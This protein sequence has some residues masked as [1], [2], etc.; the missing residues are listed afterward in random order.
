MKT[1]L[2]VTK[3][4]PL[5]VERK[6]LGSNKHVVYKSNFDLTLTLTLIKKLR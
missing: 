6:R 1:A 2:K 3:C 4:C 5:L